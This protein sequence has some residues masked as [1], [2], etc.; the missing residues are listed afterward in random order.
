[1]SSCINQNWIFN[2]CRIHLLHV[3]LY[4]VLFRTQKPFDWSS[5]SWRWWRPR[6]V[7]C[8]LRAVLISHRAECPFDGSMM[9]QQRS[10]PWWMLH[11]TR[12][13]YVARTVRMATAATET[14]VSLRMEW[15]NSEQLSV[16]HDTRLNCAKRTTPLASVLMVQGNTTYTMTRVAYALC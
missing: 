4:A 6:D 5:A 7:V 9:R 13:S 8:R 12:R 15:L 16:I 11:A 2:T 10:V 14:S 3:S 1:M